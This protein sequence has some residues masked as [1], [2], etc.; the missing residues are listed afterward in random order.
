VVTPARL[1]AAGVVL[2]LLAVGGALFLERGSDGD[3]PVLRNAPLATS[4]KVDPQTH[5]F[6]E[7]VQAQLEVVY[8]AD[9]V[10]GSSIAISPA[11]GAYRVAE[12]NES[13]AS[14]GHVDRVRYEWVLECLTAACLPRKDGAVQFPSTLLLYEERNPPALQTEKVEW[15]QLRVASRVGPDDL[16]ALSLQADARDLPAVSYRVEPRTVALV[17]YSLAGLLALA[18]LLLLIWAFDLRA[19]I[20]RALAGR[21][22]RLSALQRA[23]ALVRGHTQRGEHDRSRPALE[24]LASELRRTR[25]PDLAVDAS[26]LAWRRSDPSERSVG[27]LSDDVERVIAKDER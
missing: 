1:I 27:P 22:E 14:F 16:K 19:Q 11:F 17:G 20:S 8:D 2:A 15:P 10:R 13:R 4:S 12:R 6:G 18:G 24:R 25:E 7:R 26:R 21:R 5:L 9:R 3:A 23:L